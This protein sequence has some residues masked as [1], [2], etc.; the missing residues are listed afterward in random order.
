MTD[1][2]TRPRATLF[3]RGSAPEPARERQEA[4]IGR[5]RRLES[6]GRL[7]DLAVE[8]WPAEVPAAG[9]VGADARE[10]YAEFERWADA[11]NTSLAPAFQAR[12]RSSLIGEATRETLVLPVCCLA[13]YEG[14]EVRGVY[15]HADG[16]RTRSVEDGIA[17]LEAGAVAP[18]A[19]PTE[20]SM[21]D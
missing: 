17:A 4:R 3:V 16:E 13:L 11:R 18:A 14:E 5:L 10:R 12:E 15:P 2:P 19:G 20:R 9:P 6:D 8:T 7:A 1:A 21:A